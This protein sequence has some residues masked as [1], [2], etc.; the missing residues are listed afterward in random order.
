[1]KIRL[2]ALAVGLLPC[3]PALQ[4]QLSP[5]PLPTPAAPILA[6]PTE[7]PDPADVAKL[8]S[9]PPLP[10]KV[11]A[12]W[13]QL[14]KGYNFGECSGVDV[15][16][17]GNVWVFNR[18]N[19]PLMQFNRA[20]KFLQAWPIETF[21]VLSSHGVR[22]GPDGS[23]WCVDVQGHVVFK[24]NPDTGR[25]LMVIGNRQGTPG[26][27]DAEDAF[28]QPTNVGFRANGDIYVSD[29]YVNAR[30]IEFTAD[31]NYVRHWGKP[32]T[33]DGEFNLAHDVA[34]DSKGLVYVADRR[35]ERV[36]VFDENGKF[37]TKWTNIGSPWGLYYVAKEN[38]IYMCDGKYDRILKLGLDG[39]VLGVLSSYGKAPGK[40]DY[41]HSIAVDPTDGS[42]YTVEIKT[43]R[44]QK[45][46]RDTK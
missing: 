8:K 27:N 4:A 23:L 38:A 42:L 2:L 35:N 19:W 31:G 26:N 44:V 6:R 43:W 10:Y 7:R 15:D 46:V 20:G 34:V 36:Q 18:G 30:V 41:V 3:L 14:P 21:R 32:G 5:V 39:Q 24:L 9:G 37:I 16:K 13:P 45:W 22:V 33:G 25:I 11:D 12:N 1:M 29:G 17:Q 28:N 40:L